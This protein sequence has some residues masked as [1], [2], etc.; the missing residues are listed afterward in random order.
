[1]THKER[2]ESALE[3]FK[4]Y[5]GQESVRRLAAFIEARIECHRDTLEQE[6][7]DKYRERIKELRDLLKILNE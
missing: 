1:M 6:G 7:M 3:Q 4:P 2:Q 5:N